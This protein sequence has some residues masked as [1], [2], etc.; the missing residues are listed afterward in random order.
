VAAAT[1]F[2][3]VLQDLLQVAVC[4]FG[5]QACGPF[6]FVTMAQPVAVAGQAF[7][8]PA[9]RELLEAGGFHSLSTVD[10]AWRHFAHFCPFGHS[11]KKLPSRVQTYKV[12]VE[13]KYSCCPNCILVC[14]WDIRGNTRDHVVQFSMA[15]CTHMHLNQLNQLPLLVTVGAATWEMPLPRHVEVPNLESTLKGVGDPIG[16]AVVGQLAV[17]EV[18]VQELPVNEVFADQLF[19]QQDTFVQAADDEELHEEEPPGDKIV[20]DEDAVSSE[21]SVGVNLNL[22]GTK[23][24]I[25]EEKAG[26]EDVADDLMDLEV[27]LESSNK[28]SIKEPSMWMNAI[29][30]HN[31]CEEYALEL[32]EGVMYE[33]L[34]EKV[35][36]AF[37]QNGRRLLKKAVKDGREEVVTIQG[38]RFEY[39]FGECCRVNINYDCFCT[40]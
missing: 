19:V 2:L 28:E 9:F 33:Q 8:T 39:F 35:V 4:L 24:G 32:S 6:S 31:V 38:E 12:R 25:A 21:Q 13:Y 16:E 17:G 15:Q 3:S 27:D 7:V 40:H 22:S 23:D 14:H 1:L 5:C 20:F 37:Q 36:L 30:D 34:R 18:P 11:F 29:L 26:I 10:G